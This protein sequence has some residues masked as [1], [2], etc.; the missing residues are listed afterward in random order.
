MLKRTLAI[1]ALAL[2][3]GGVQAQDYPTR[4]I[5]G[6]IMW[7]A[8]GAT[9]NLARVL[10]PAVEKELGQ[11]VVLVNRPGGV[12]AI[13]TQYVNSRPSDG[14]NVL[15]GAENP[16]LHRV[17]GLSDIDYREFYPV[18]IFGRN[19]QVFVVKPDAPWQTLTEL[20]T[21][22][23]ANPGK[24]RVGSTGP[25]GS[26][27]VALGMLA[28]VTEINV[29]PVPFDGEGPGLTALQ[30]GHV[31]FMA[32]SLPAASELMRAGRVRP[33][34]MLDGETVEA[35]PEVPLITTEFPDVAKFLPWGSFQGVFV[36]RDTPEPII[37]KLTAAF[38][39][40]V[41]DPAAQEFINASGM[42]PMN[43]SGAEADEFMT[44]WQSVTSWVLQD[45]GDAKVSPEDLGIPRP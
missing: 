35:F 17:L 22:I 42:V 33:L 25:G 44:R 30:G 28:A 12:G 2:M 15:F 24:V 32:V 34:A 43:I 41:E 31:D 4:D 13:A 16:Q 40:G 45:N 6:T 20:V 36:K 37:A 18:M 19:I 9:D 1:A 23:Q 26:P 14:Y 27:M 8:G 38:A 7:G 5:Q 10:T 11:T 39:A 29:T 21:E 3:A